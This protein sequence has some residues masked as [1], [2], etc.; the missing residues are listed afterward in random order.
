EVGGL[1][2]AGS[3]VVLA[4]AM[5]RL[6]GRWAIAYLVPSI[7]VWIGLWRAGVHP[8]LTGVVVAFVL[9]AAAARWAG[10]CLGPWVAFAIMPLFALAN[11]AVTVHSL[12][13]DWLT[14]LRLAGGVVIALV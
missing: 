13:L 3:G 6:S 2:I 7:A 5:R 14:S 9:P 11:A 10:Q 12:T 8:A 4:L 1:A